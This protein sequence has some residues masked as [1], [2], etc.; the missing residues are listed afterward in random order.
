[1]VLGQ[2]RVAD[3]SNEITAIP[4]L[5][6]LLDL[7]GCIITL[8]AM[9]TQKA[10]AAQINQGKA[11]YVLTLKANHPKLY[12]QVKTWFEQAQ[13]ENFAGIELSLDARVETG[14]HRLEKRQVFSVPVT[15]LPPLHQQAD[16]VGLRSIVMVVRVRQL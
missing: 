11:D 15:Q 1:M 9:G 12:E 4:A 14:H 5:L 3:K 8:D 2:L 16:W 7:S 10:I 13:A 6:E